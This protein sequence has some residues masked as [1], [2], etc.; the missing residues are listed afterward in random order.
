MTL[1]NRRRFTADLAFYEMLLA[2]K[3]VAGHRMG[4]AE[5]PREGVERTVRLLR[6]VKRG[7]EAQ[8]AWIKENLVRIPPNLFVGRNRDLLLS[9]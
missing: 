1:R 8:D 4:D 9:F 6:G 2:G 5:Y 3:I 7:L